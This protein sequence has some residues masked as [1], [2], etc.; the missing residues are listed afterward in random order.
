MPWMCRSTSF[1]SIAETALAREQRRRISVDETS[2]S[3]RQREKCVAE[4]RLRWRS[5]F[6]AR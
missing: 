2:G 6:A 1:G 3:A 4:S 5:R